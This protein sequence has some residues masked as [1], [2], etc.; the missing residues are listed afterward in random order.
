MPENDKVFF[1]YARED[2]EFALKL[3]N[4][5]RD[6]GENVWIDQLDIPAGARWDRA[7]EAALAECPFLLV[8]LSPTSVGSATVMDEVSYAVEEGKTLIPVLYQA[9][10]I[11]FRLRRFQYADFTGDYE[12]ALNEILT[13][14]KHH[15]I[16]VGLEPTPPPSEPTPPTPEPPVTYP[17]TTMGT[18]DAADEIVMQVEPAE[19]GAGFVQVCL[20]VAIDGGGWWKGI[21]LNSR[22]PTLEGEEKEGIQ[23]TVIPAQEVKVNFWKAKFGGRHAPVGQGS[24]DMTEFGGYR[25]VFKWVKD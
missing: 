21:G 24:V 25:V 4:D 22:Q 13:H 3:A 20:E 1:S 6:A 17:P 2:A 7:I 10:K 11:P 8:V 12:E 18:E 9:C 14:L 5:F 16:R 19:I 23:C 15:S